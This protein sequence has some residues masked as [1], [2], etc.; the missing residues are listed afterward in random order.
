MA[1]NRKLGNNRLDTTDKGQAYF[2]GPFGINKGE[3]PVVDQGWEGKVLTVNEDGVTSLT[4]AVKNALTASTLEGGPIRLDPGEDPNP[5]GTSYTSSTFLF[6]SS[7][8]TLLGYDLYFRQNGNV[9]KWKWFEGLLESGLLYG[10]VVTYSGSFVYVSPGSGILV[11]HNA[12][13]GS[14][15]G[16]IVDY[17]TWGPITQS[18]TNIATQQLTYIYIDDTGSLQ[19]QS[20]AFTSQQYHTSIPLGA[21]AHFNY[22]SIGSFGGSVQTSYDQTSQILTFVDAFGP[23]KISGYGITGQPSS[24]KISVGSGTSFIH[25][26]F[27]DS[28][29]QFPSEIP[30]TSQLTA[31]IVYVHRSGSGVKFDSNNNLYYTDLKPG[32]YDPGTGNTASLSNNNWTIQ[33]AYSEPKTGIVYVYYGQNV[34]PTYDEAVASVSSDSFTEGDTFDYTTFLGFLILKSNTTDITN[35]SDNKIITAGLFR[36]GAG[37]AGGGSAVTS[38]DDLSDVSILSPTNGQA[39]VYNSGTSLWENGTP[40]TSSYALTASFLPVGTYQITSS[41]AINALTTSNISPAITNN[42]DNRVVTATGGGTINGETNLTFDGSLLSVIGNISASNGVTGSLFGTSSWAVSASKSIN[43]QTASN[44]FP[45]ITNNTSTYVLTATGDGTINGNSNLTFDGNDLTLSNG[46]IKLPVNGYV[47]G[48]D[49]EILNGT[50]VLFPANPPAQPNDVLAGTSS[51]L[52]SNTQIQLR[53]TSEPNVVG[54]FNSGSIFFKT[55]S[56]SGMTYTNEGRLG[57][58]V[59][60]PT[61]TLQIQGNVSASSYTGSLFGTSSW[62]VSASQALTASFIAPTG[63]AFV[64]GGNSFGTTAL[65]GTNDSQS[66][67]FE[68]SGSVRMTISS[69]GNVG[70]GTTIPTTT[71]NVSGTT[72]LQ[73]GQTTVRGSGATSATTA[74][75]VENSAA[76]A[77]LTI[78]DDGTSAFNTNHLYVSSSGNVGIGTT[79]PTARLQI[80]GTSNDGISLDANHTLFNG[81]NARLP[82]RIIVG[83]VSSAY[84]KIMYNAVPSAS[85]SWSYAAND[86]A[87][88]INMGGGNRMG[89]EYVAAG[90]AGTSFSS[91][92]TIMVLVSGS[93]SVGIGTT[94]PAALLDVNGNT[95]IRGALT[96]SIISASSNISSSTLRTTGNTAI[97]GT[98]NVAGATT[99]VGALTASNISASSNISGST[100]HITGNE[101]IGGT[102]TITGRL[103]AN[104]GI[105]TTT[106]TASGAISSSAGLLVTTVTATS[107]VTVGGTL[108]VTGATTLTGALTSSNISASS[109]ISGS[110]LHIVGSGSILGNVGI[111]TTTPQGPLHIRGTS[112]GGITPAIFLDTNGFDPNEP[113]DIRLASGNAKG[114]RIIASS[115]LSSIPGGASIQFYSNDSATFGGQFRIDSGN[116]GSSAIIFRTNDTLTAVTERMRIAGNGTVS[117]NGAGATSATTI[118]SIADSTPTTRFTILGDG[119]SAFN[120]NHLYISGSG[121]VGIGITTPSTLLH[122]SGTTQTEGVAT[123]INNLTSPTFISGWAGRG[124]RLDYASNQTSSLDLDNLTV[125]GQ[126]RVFE[127][128]INQIRATNGSLFVSSVG[129]V[130]SASFISGTDYFLTFDT[131]SGDVG[132]GFA[133]GDIIRAQRVSRAAL[134]GSGV[135]QSIAGNLVYQSDLTVRNVTNLSSLTASLISGTAPSGGMDFVRLG[136]S[137]SLNRQGTIYLTADD[138]YAPFIDVVDGVK[139]HSE[140]NNASGSGGVKVRMGKLNGITSPTFGPLTASGNNSLYGFWASGSAYLE[141]GINATFGNIAGWTINTSAITKSGLELNSSGTF[142]RAGTIVSNLTSGTGVL[143]SGSGDAVIGNPTGHRISFIG[144][145]LTISAS[146]AILKGDTVEISGSN[147]HLI[148]GSITASNAL[149]SGTITANTGAIGGWNITSTAITRSNVELNSSNNF[150]RLGAVTNLLTGSGIYLTGSGEALIGSASGHRISFIGGNLTIS[151]SNAVLKGNTVEISGSNFHLLNGSISASNATLSGTITANAG[152]IGG[153]AITQDAITGSGFFLSG[154]ATGDGFFISASNFNVKANGQVTGSNVLFTGGKVGGF[155][156]SSD[157]ISGTGFFLS[158]SATGNGFFI[159]ASNFNVKANGTITASAG[160]IGGFNTTSDKIEST[161]SF[162]SGSFTSPYISLKANGQITGSEVL[163][164][165]L[166]SDGNVYTHFDTSTGIIDARNVGRVVISD[167]NEYRIYIDTTTTGSGATP[168]TM[169]RA[170]K[171]TQA[172]NTSYLGGEFTYNVPSTVLPNPSVT[173]PNSI[174]PLGSNVIDNGGSP[175]TALSAGNGWVTVNQHYVQLLQGE[176]T[177]L[178]SFTMMGRINTA[179]DS[180]YSSNNR[181]HD[182]R[183]VIATG[184]YEYVPTGGSSGNN[185]YN[186]FGGTQNLIISASTNSFYRAQAVGSNDT[187]RIIAPFFTGSVADTSTGYKSGVFPIPDTF[188]GKYVTI[189]LQLRHWSEVNNYGNQTNGANFRRGWYGLET[190]IKGITLTATRQFTGRTSQGAIPL[191]TSS[192]PAF[193]SSTG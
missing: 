98:L 55:P 54:G 100:L 150:I 74:L 118:L 24:L 4:T 127:L 27:Y 67:Q 114:I 120:T 125:R 52:A 189:I 176:N 94:S 130:V 41:W 137:E 99:L 37:G 14:E 29:P 25:G 77:R 169:S 96:A 162:T 88:A 175:I 11:D 49:T 85:A 19:Q 182:F 107:N 63:N 59:S 60:N 122:V 70:I 133:R 153:F 111:G 103:T 56:G 21:V 65:L 188:Q 62:A 140:W 132:H 42:I 117:I 31:S 34:Y 13:T 177:F 89:F 90:T 192:A 138:S 32:F 81:V 84:P 22:T 35:T 2:D 92:N 101:N 173:I 16:P 7:S 104:S 38:L 112:V 76:A 26:G 170:V 134:T 174:L 179:I 87:W 68:T 73:G 45:A 28:N 44:I 147:F 6:Q 93:N 12:V 46:N 80:A 185:T 48:G 47:F 9:V 51:F 163:L 123:F 141:G 102:S 5:T 142:F 71:L 61:N 75:R 97:G 50:H 143:L 128:V 135:S 119:T 167:P 57:I 108:S 129:K 69:S 72:L 40:L 172:A 159:S 161:G 191:V 183:I 20:T 156:L 91:W 148:N 164:R 106:I 95:I 105:T 43:A 15:I 8:N 53:S 168:A 121:N 116:T 30:T 82:G 180:T 136:N 160:L 149:L 17:I 86:T 78:L 171:V 124:W 193:I 115:S 110:T 155:N 154:S 10:G 109:N 146:N 157:A 3:L 131:A 187:V 83:A 145:N 178:L 166:Q 18:I 66:L 190:K 126:L 1:E 144:S 152:R 23:L 186:K 79:T 158:G 58:G 139:S 33:R 151:A 36:G 39:L 64:Q 184:S 181:Y 165:R 113:V